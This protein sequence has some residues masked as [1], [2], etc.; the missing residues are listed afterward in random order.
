MDDENLSKTI[1]E[2][3][4][5]IVSAGQLISFPSSIDRLRAKNL[6]A[7]SVD[8]RKDVELSFVIANA[9]RPDTSPV[10]VTTLEPERG[11]EVQPLHAVADQ[12]PVH[13][14]SRMHDLER[15]VHVHGCAGE[16]V[17][18]VDPDNIGI[19]KLF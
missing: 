17:I 18:F 15:R 5:Q 12:V 10:N 9:R 1:V 16:V 2:Q 6:K 14:V 3:D 7:H 4:R 8:V 13:Q 19:F 11:T